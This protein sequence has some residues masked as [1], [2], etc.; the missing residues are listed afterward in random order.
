MK[1]LVATLAGAALALAAHPAAASWTRDSDAGT[2]TGLNAGY[3]VHYQT[4]TTGYGNTQQSLVPGGDRLGD[5]LPTIESQSG[6]G[7]T[8]KAAPAATRTLSASR[9]PCRPRSWKSGA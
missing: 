8:G 3:D 9:A 4:V 7:F 2:W 6:L 1:K 5:P